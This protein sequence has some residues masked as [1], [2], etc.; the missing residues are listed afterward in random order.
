MSQQERA[1]SLVDSLASDLELEGLAFD[2]QNRIVLQIGEEHLVTLALDGQDPDSL[3]LFA[4]ITAASPEA[5][6]PLWRALKANYLWGESAGATFAVEPETGVLVL[7]RRL[8]LT[9]LDYPAFHTALERFADLA[10]A[11]E[12]ESDKDR[13]A[14][15]KEEQSATDAAAELSR[16]FNLLG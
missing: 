9:R 2:E 8:D 16:N 15:T 3:Y 6:D 11:W 10:A 14:G 4:A 5:P 13:P 1:Q 12:S 7:H